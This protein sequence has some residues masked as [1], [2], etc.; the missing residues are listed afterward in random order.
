MNIVT[1]PNRSTDL[2]ATTGIIISNDIYWTIVIKTN[3]LSTMVTRTS[4]PITFPALIHDYYYSTLSLLYSGARVLPNHFSCRSYHCLSNSSGC[5]VICTLMNAKLNIFVMRNGNVCCWCCL[6][7][8]PLR[9][10]L[11][12][13]IF[14]TLLIFTHCIVFSLGM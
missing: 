5:W 8:S 7:Q 4:R 6:L 9:I 3:S 13:Y 2:I 12:L 14:I 10:H 11:N 1:C